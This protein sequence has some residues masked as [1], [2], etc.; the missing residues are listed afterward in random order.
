VKPSRDE[1]ERWIART[2]RTQRI[3]AVALAAA[4]AIALA[5]AVTFGAIGGFSLVIVALVAI[6]GFWIT[7]SH[8]LDWRRKL[9]EL[10]PPPDAGRRPQL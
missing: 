4:F 2:K 1:L 8:L 5:L 10:E 9:A 6:C 3:L 7:G